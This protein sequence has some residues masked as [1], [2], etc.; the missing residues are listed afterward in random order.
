MASARVAETGPEAVGALAAFLIAVIV[1]YRPVR[2]LATSVI[3]LQS[4]LIAAQM[5]RAALTEL[6]GGSGA[7]AH[8]AVEGDA[9]RRRDRATSVSATTAMSTCCAASR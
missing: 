2:R 6:R 4:G 3:H 7:A 9:L 5:I 1:A 8:A